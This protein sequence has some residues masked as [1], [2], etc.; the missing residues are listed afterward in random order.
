MYKYEL[1]GCFDVFLLVRIKRIIHQPS[2]TAKK[3]LLRHHLAEL[4]AKKKNQMTVS[5]QAFYCKRVKYTHLSV[6]SVHRAAHAFAF[7]TQY[8]FARSDNIRHRPIK[9]A[10]HQHLEEAEEKMLAPGRDLGSA[11]HLEE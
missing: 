9:M 1:F 8:Q 11:G 10:K 6:L 2:G 3:K 4:K 5:R 7:L